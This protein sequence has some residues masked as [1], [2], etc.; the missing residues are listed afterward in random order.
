M[1]SRARGK[2]LP[3]LEGDEDLILSI[4]KLQMVHHRL[5]AILLFRRICPYGRKLGQT[6]HLLPYSR[7]RGERILSYTGSRL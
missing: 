1:A 7:K 4:Q 6:A 3:L 5:G 2:V